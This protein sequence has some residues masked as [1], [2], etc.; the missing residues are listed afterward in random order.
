MKVDGRLAWEL[1]DLFKKSLIF[2]IL[3]A[4]ISYPTQS[5]FGKSCTVLPST[6]FNSMEPL[7]QFF[8]QVTPTMKVGR[9]GRRILARRSSG[10]VPPIPSHGSLYE[11]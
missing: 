9:E 7:F 1:Y 2:D 5:N 3:N 4:Y 11:V 10:L 8:V 6:P